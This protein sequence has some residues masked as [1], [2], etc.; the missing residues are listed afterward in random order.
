MALFKFATCIS[1]VGLFQSLRLTLEN[2]N[3]KQDHKS[4]LMK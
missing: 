1:L 2:N 3:T 4:A